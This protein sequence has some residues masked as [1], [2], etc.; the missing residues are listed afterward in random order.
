MIAC[1]CRLRRRVRESAG[2]AGHFASGWR[3][4]RLPRA[5][6]RLFG[7]AG[8]RAAKVKELGALALAAGLVA[9]NCRQEQ[10]MTPPP[11]ADELHQR[12]RR[13]FES[14][15]DHPVTDRPPRQG[16]DGQWRSPDGRAIPFTGFYSAE[17]HRYWVQKGGGL[18]GTEFWFGPFDLPP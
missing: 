4:L 12:L 18:G 10:R 16:G 17:E 3:V 14:R 15:S 8:V 6:A 7:P 11:N 13:D 9:A 2:A 5:R 1:R